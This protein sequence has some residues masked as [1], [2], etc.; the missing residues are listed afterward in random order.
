MSHTLSCT[1]TLETER[2]PIYWWPLIFEAMHLH[3]FFFSSP[4][5]AKGVSHYYYQRIE[6]PRDSDIVTGS[7]KRFW[8]E[9][10][11][12]RNEDLMAYFWSSD[13]DYY[14]LNVYLKPVQNSNQLRISVYFEGAEVMSLSLQEAGERLFHVL[15][16]L[17]TLYLT[18]KPCTGEVHWSWAGEDFPTWATFGKELVI[19]HAEQPGNENSANKLIRRD[20]RETERSPGYPYDAIY[21]LDPVPLPRT[22]V[23]GGSHWEYVSLEKYYDRE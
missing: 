4:D 8:E 17:E 13:A 14:N 23:E 15:E 11:S 12:E 10:Y 1:F 3:G 7:F 21:L 6:N 18:C 2:G 9:V 20:L 16:C 5:Y 19:V 22:F